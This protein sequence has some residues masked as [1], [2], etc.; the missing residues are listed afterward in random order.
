[1]HEMV[2]DE[3]DKEGEGEVDT[4]EERDLDNGEEALFFKLSADK[5]ERS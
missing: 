4:D 2:D 3:E 1:M 5:C